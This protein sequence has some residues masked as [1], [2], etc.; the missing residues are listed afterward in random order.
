MA[1]VRHIGK[2]GFSRRAKKIYHS[3]QAVAC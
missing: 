3:E 1:D 2:H